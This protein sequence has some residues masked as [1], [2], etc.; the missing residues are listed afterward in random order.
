MPGKNQSIWLFVQMFV[1]HGENKDTQENSSLELSCFLEV[2]MNLKQVKSISW[3]LNILTCGAT[4]GCAN[5]SK[6]YSYFSNMKINMFS[7]YFGF[8]N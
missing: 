7:A 4:A 6:S 5:S 1:M 2:H 3:G 8:R